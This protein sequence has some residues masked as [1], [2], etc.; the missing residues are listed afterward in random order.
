MNSTCLELV[1]CVIVGKEVVARCD[2]GDIT[3][4]AGV[5]LVSL[6]DKKLGLT[7]AMAGCLTDTR[8]QSKVE[9]SSVEITRERGLLNMAGKMR[10]GWEGQRVK[11]VKRLRGSRMTVGMPRQ[12]RLESGCVC[13]A[14]R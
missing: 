9:H 3:S 4:D 10:R 12:G 2:G 11:K 1:F 8:Q 7:E 14:G 13:V 6:A 5:L